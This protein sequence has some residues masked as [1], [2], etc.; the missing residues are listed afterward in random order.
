MANRPARL[1]QWIQGGGSTSPGETA[2]GLEEECP[3]PGGRETAA[4]GGL[5]AVPCRSDVRRIAPD[6]AFF[7]RQEFAQG[8]RASPEG[9]L[10]LLIEKPL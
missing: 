3:P 6:G 9:M 2:E 7:I 4:A 1:R 8:I 10:N 5:H